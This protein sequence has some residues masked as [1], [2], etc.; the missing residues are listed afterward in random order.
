ML[1]VS[2]TYNR[3]F[4]IRLSEVKENRREIKISQ[5]ADDT[6]LLCLDLSSVEKGLQ[7]AVDFREISGLRLNLEKTKAMWLGKWLGNKSKSFHLKWV[8]S[9]T[10][11]LGIYFFY[12]E[13]GN[14]EMNFNLKIDKLQTNLDTWKSRDLTLSGKV[15]IIKALRVSSHI[16]GFK[17][18]CSKGYYK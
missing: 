17:Y 8:S 7:I 11:I 12:D 4:A 6:N 3:N 15:M 10:R 14:N 13:K 18:Q 1:L 9:P 16:F 2:S 5:F